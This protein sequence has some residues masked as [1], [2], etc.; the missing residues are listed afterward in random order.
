MIARQ[1]GIVLCRVGA[2]VLTVQ[3]VRSLGYTL[4]GL[5]YGN[6]QFS[7]EAIAFSLLT[8][9]P[10]LA[11]IGLWV[12]AD[13]ICSIVDPID[14]TATLEPLT[15]VDL[16]RIGTALIGM[17]LAISAV[18]YGINIEVANLA[19]P[20][21]GAERQVMMDEHAAR[22]IGIRA[23]YIAQLTFG[24]ALLIGRNRISIMLAKAKYAGVIKR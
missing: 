4:P 15:G 21:L 17:Y 16:V 19:R 7:S 11:A 13:R 24:L 18:I 14:S 5:I 2:A 8:I 1:I 22:I 3:A 6:N 10:G 20:D 12:F 9:L 23:S